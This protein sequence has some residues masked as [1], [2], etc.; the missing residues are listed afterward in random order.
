[1]RI[2]GGIIGLIAGIFGFIL[3]I[4]TLFF[5]V[6]GAAWEIETGGDLSATFRFLGW[7][8]LLF[9]LLV[10]VFSFVAIVLKRRWP[11]TAMILSSL[12]GAVFGGPWV[13]ILMVLSL[14]GGVLVFFG[15]P[16]RVSSDVASDLES[17]QSTPANEL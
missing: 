8:G 16:K 13:A 5:G 12:F 1:M 15:G 3:A 4:F 11:G 6:I 9:S 2:G 14:I 7:G 17:P 10:T